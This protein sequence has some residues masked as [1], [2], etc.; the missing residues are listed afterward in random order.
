M[1]FSVAFV[2]LFSTIYPTIV[3]KKLA[4]AFSPFSPLYRYFGGCVVFSRKIIDFSDYFFIFIQ[5]IIMAA[6]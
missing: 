1:L 3:K 4:W 2:F 5:K 6:S